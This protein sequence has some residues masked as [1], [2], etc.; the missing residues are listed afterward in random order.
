MVKQTMKRAKQA[1]RKRVL[2]LS[3]RLHVGDAGPLDTAIRGARFC[4]THA[5]K[6]CF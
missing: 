5:L 4:V 6:D 1:Y 2:C 3:Q